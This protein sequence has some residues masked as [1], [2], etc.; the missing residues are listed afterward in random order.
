MPREEIPGG[1]RLV[2]HPGSADTLRALIDI[3]RG[4]LRLD[5]VRALR[6]IRGDD[7]AGDRRSDHPRDVDEGVKGAV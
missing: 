5:Y 1:L 7:R 2:V 4:V 6:A 3:E